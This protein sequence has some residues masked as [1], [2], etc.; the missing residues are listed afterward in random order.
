VIS[1]A[2][3]VLELLSSDP[4]LDECINREGHL[5]DGHPSAA[6]SG[7]RAIGKEAEYLTSLELIR[8]GHLVHGGTGRLLET[9]DSD[10]AILAGDLLYAEGLVRMAALNDLAAIA[11]LSRMICACAVA[12][13]VADEDRAEAVWAKSCAVIGGNVG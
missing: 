13:S 1:A 5:G 3:Q 2:T 10:L 9:A 11:E 4:L 7:P 8:E 6:A 12:R